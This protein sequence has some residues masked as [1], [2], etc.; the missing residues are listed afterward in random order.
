MQTN[1]VSKC[2][3]EMVIFFTNLEIR[4]RGMGSSLTGNCEENIAYISGKTCRPSVGWQTTN[5][6]PTFTHVFR[7]NFPICRAEH[8]SQ[9]ASPVWGKEFVSTL[10]QLNA[11]LSSF[12]QWENCKWYH[13]S[14]TVKHSCALGESVSQNK[15]NCE[16]E[17]LNPLHL[18]I[19][20]HILH[21]VLY[22][23][24]KALTRRIC[25]LI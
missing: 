12:G 5:C 13:I 4:G 25:L 1:I 17:L 23:F 19:S 15:G 8:Q 7:G 10:W 2:L 14:S 22:T 9:S 20:M 3:L 11:F 6:R 21:T 24:P 16:E 18:S